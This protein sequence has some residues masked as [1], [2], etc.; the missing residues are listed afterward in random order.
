M[1]EKTVSGRYNT[2]TQDDRVLEF[3]R[4]RIPM[5]NESGRGIDANGWVRR[6]VLRALKSKLLV[7][8]DDKSSQAPM[9]LE[10]NPKVYNQGLGSVVVMF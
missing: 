5:V 10:V 7:N 9:K 8:P 3:N 4:V 6:E 1:S 2:K